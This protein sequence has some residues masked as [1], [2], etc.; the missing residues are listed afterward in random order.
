[1]HD[2]ELKLKQGYVVTFQI[3]ET[4]KRVFLNYPPTKIVIKRPYECNFITIS[5]S[6]KYDLEFMDKTIASMEKEAMPLKKYA[7]GYKIITHAVKKD[8]KDNL[9]SYNIAINNSKKKDYV[10]FADGSLVEYNKAWEV[11]SPKEIEDNNFCIDVSGDLECQ[12]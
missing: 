9:Q 1:M 5:A 12:L 11:I 3:G 4:I 10:L 7:I 8:K 2:D 6:L